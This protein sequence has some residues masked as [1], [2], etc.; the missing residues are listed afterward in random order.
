MTESRLVVAWEPEN[1]RKHVRE[2]SLSE[3]QKTWGKVLDLF[4]T[5]IFRVHPYGLEWEGLEY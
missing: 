4:I 2:R 3:T 5:F 1:T